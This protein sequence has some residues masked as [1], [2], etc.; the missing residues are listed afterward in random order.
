MKVELRTA[1]IHDSARLKA[2]DLDD[3]VASSGGEDDTYDWDHELQREVEWREFLIAEVGSVPVGMVVLIDAL[4][5]E[6]H[7][8]G[9]DVPDG[10][11][12]IDIWIGEQV[13][14][15]K[16][17][18]AVM[19]MQAL[20]RCFIDHGARVV[21]IDPLRSNVRAIAF[22]RRLGFRS[23]GPR[24]FGNDDCLVMSFHI[25]DFHQ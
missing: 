17:F 25:D 3:E 14:R 8:W 4:R 16:G 2:W 23:V 22:Y 13:H 12:A 5:E 20:R 7:Y 18:G 19:M 15:S 11:W 10:S 9:N 24:R 6:S 21:L 1:T